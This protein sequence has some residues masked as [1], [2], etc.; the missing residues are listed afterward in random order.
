MDLEA[1]LELERELKTK[2]K[3][4]MHFKLEHQSKEDQGSSRTRIQEVHLAM[5]NQNNIHAH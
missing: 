3:L 5:N 4:E 1:E 2:Q